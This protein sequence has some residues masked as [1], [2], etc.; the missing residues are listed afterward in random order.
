MT[1]QRQRSNPR[2]D[3]RKSRPNSTERVATAS[4]WCVAAL[5]L[6]VFC[7]LLGD[8]LRQGWP[9]VTWTFLTTSPQNAGL[10]GGIAPM[11][12]STGLVLLVCIMVAL[13][14]GLATAIL[15]TQFSSQ[16]QVWERSIRFSLDLLAG[17][18]S[19]VFGL[20]GN[21]FFAKTL[22]LGFSILSGGLTLACMVLPLLIRSVQAGFESVPQ[23]YR[24]AAAALGLSRS[25]T[26]WRLILP[27][28]MPSVG[29]G[30][31]L[32][33]GR[34]I[35]ET[36]ALIF[37]SGYV[38]R[39]PTSILDSGRTLSVHI[40]DLALNV[41]GGS[42]RAYSTALV[43]VVLLMIINS[44]VSWLADRFRQSRLQLL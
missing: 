5:T 44:S 27:A 43:L 15:L 18:P 6:G 13:P 1:I 29:V 36:A 17:V 16:S 38:D 32:G 4:I 21:A 9:N 33:I 30:V 14:L 26:L 10:A 3:S 40:Y 24:R 39:M 37:T 2:K 28:A 41:A 23:D 19:I 20:F 22:G 34:A 8:I 31:L 7:W 25:A 12:V 11:L 35:A 42:P